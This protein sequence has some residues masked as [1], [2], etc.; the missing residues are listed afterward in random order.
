MGKD[1]L[2]G[3]CGQTYRI[4]RTLAHAGAPLGNAPLRK[5]PAAIKSGTT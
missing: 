4:I 2:A 5:V 1:H 3:L